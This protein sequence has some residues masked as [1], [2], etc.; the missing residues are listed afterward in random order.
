MK[1]VENIKRLIKRAHVTTDPDA[2]ERILG[3]ALADLKELGQKR[4]AA[5]QPNIWRI[6]IK[7]KITKL[8]AAAV[9][10]VTAFILW[11]DGGVTS[12]VYAFSDMPEIMR[13][14]ETIHSYGWLYRESERVVGAEGPKRYPTIGWIDLRT[15]C[16]RTT[17]WAV[18]AD[19]STTGTNGGGYSSQYTQQ[20]GWKY[21]HM[22]YVCDGRYA[23]MVNHSRKTVEFS[24]LTPVRA[25]LEARN[26]QQ[27]F[28]Q[29]IICLA[30]EIL[31]DCVKIGSEQVAG[32]QLDV[33]ERQGP[34]PAPHRHL[35]KVQYWIS[36]ASGELKRVA[37]WQKNEVDEPWDMR[38]ETQIE[39]NAVPPP[40]TFQTEPPDG[41]ELLNAKETAVEQR[42][43]FRAIVTGTI[44]GE[45][46]VSFTLQN[47]SVIACWSA[48]ERG[49]E[50]PPEELF[51]ALEVGGE[52]PMLP[53]VI[54]GLR[55]R[56]APIYGV[57]P[58]G[59]D[60]QSADYVGRHLTVTKKDGRLYEWS[61][62]VPDEET[63]SEGATQP[64]KLFY[65]LLT[66]FNPEERAD[67]DAKYL[68]HECVRSYTIRADEF[69]T[70]VRRAMEEFSDTGSVPD[71][72]T[73]EYVVDLAEQIRAELDK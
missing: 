18:F 43:K 32:E 20:G 46:A 34:A 8:A 11:P 59:E 51:E 25:A 54:Y 36:P 24:Q 19:S 48:W 22:E 57:R 9:I 6:I 23:M 60:T 16:V 33:W 31:A 40:G 58:Y 53:V 4:S 38:G 14:S 66:R 71:Y 41:Y 12:K 28:F 65:A 7:S 62:Y 64:Q 29:K 3:D 63:L 55:H 67:R 52:L 37:H 15:G 72:V 50:G 45:V 44:E 1:R 73:Y 5:T 27:N 17:V 61:I 26:W 13:S 56:P 49:A 68:A 30:P 70:F 69:D 47:G 2:D 10:L 35:F 21:M 42:P 39:R